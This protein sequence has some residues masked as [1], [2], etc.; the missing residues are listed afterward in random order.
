MVKNV[1]FW[2][3]FAAIIIGGLVAELPLLGVLGCA[4]FYAVACSF[5]VRKDGGEDRRTKV[6][7]LRSLVGWGCIIAALIIAM[8]Q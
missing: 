3:I 5:R 6:R 2:V 8:M 7:V 4:G 1:L